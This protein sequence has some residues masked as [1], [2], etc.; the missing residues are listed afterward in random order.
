MIAFV[1]A[2]FA[3]QRDGREAALTQYRFQVAHGLPRAAKDQRTLRIYEAQQIDDGGFLPVM[4]DL[5]GAVFDVRMAA[6]FACDVD[7]ERVPL[8][9]PGEV[10]DGFRKR[11]RKQQRAPC[12]RRL[13]QNE[14]QVL[15]KAHVEHFVGFVE[16]DGAYGAG[17]QCA[18]LQVIA[19]T[20]RRAHHDMDAV[21]ELAPLARRIHAANQSD[22]PR[23]G[24]AVKPRELALNLDR[25][26]SRWRDDQR[27]RLTRR[28]QRVGAFQQR[29][30][31]R[32]TIGDRLARARLRRDQQIAALG[33]GLQD[34]G[35]D[36]CGL[37]IVALGE[38]AGE[39]GGSGQKCQNQ[40]FS[41]NGYLDGGCL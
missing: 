15:A 17:L 3:G 33:F 36:R 40:A 11:R 21:G 29:V 6:H 9:I 26:F 19:Q 41:R 7:A 1:L 34:R 38:G 31:D 10:H 39:R 23:A 27:Q 37:G 8:I 20:P 32:Q 30:G 5:D 28:P 13:L 24:L 4:R 22:Y 14:L 35:L 18:P 25:E 2:E 16:D 12:L